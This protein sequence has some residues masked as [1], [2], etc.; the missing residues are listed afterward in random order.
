M[1]NMETQLESLFDRL[2]KHNM[3]IGVLEFLAYFAISLLVTGETSEDRKNAVA[4]LRE[5][6]AKDSGDEFA[7]K[8]I[9]ILDQA[10]QRAED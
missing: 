4:A 9:E 2:E 10:L 7:D 3:Q 8:I 6:V 1:S 5:H